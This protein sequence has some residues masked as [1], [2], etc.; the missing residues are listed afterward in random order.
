M[1]RRQ[2]RKLTGATVDV[3]TETALSHRDG[4]G[5][6]LITADDLRKM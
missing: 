1:V 2:R 5:D 4:M 3:G 6:G